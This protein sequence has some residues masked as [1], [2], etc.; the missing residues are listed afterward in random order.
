MR[1]A[2]DGRPDIGTAN[3]DGG[4]RM[5]LTDEA[6]PG[7]VMLLPFASLWAHAEGAS[8]A[9]EREPESSEGRASGD[10]VDEQ[11]AVGSLDGEGAAE[12]TGSLEVS[13]E[14]RAPQG[15]RAPG[16]DGVAAHAGSTP[17]TLRGPDEMQ[18][19]GQEPPPSPA[20][21]VEA[22]WYLDEIPA[23]PP[24][25]RLPGSVGLAGFSAV[26]GSHRSVEAASGRAGDV[27]ASETQAE[28]HAG[29][30]RSRGDRSGRSSPAAPSAGLDEVAAECLANEPGRIA[31]GAT[32]PRNRLNIVAAL[33]EAAGVTTV[34][35]SPIRRFSEAGRG[36]RSQHPRR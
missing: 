34:R 31:S 10:G 27:P 18:P 8:E 19:A 16:T 36:S 9:G 12:P 30:E 29:S 5:D 2:A 7:G 21:K 33:E 6:G 24:P 35:V 32:A 17:A 22:E 11:D 20:N 26:G 23:D 28:A 13:R 25:G 15:G 3:D 4:V 1:R 14:T